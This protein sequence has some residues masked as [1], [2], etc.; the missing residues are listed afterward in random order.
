MRCPHC[1]KTV[2]YAIATQIVHINVK[3]DEYGDFLDNLSAS[4][5][6]YD[7]AYDFDDPVGD[8]RCPVCG[9]YTA[10]IGDFA[11]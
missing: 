1:G 2:E 3:V 9:E 4:G 11:D 5:N 7:D 6:L 8:Y 10:Y